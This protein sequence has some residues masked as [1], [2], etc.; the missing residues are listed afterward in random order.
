MQIKPKQAYF[1][2]EKET[3]IHYGKHREKSINVWTKYAYQI[4][5][6]IIQCNVKLTAE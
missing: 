1:E 2:R 4:K 3:G 5:H 6:D